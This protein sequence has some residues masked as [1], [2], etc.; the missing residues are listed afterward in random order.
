[1]FSLDFGKP[2][3]ACLMYRS[4]SLFATSR[5]SKVGHDRSKIDVGLD[6]TGEM[7]H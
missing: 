5:R 2:L 3:T 6:S 1:M 4:G 7:P